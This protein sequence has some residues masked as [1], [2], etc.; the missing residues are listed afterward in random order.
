M[1]LSGGS[2]GGG[3]TSTTLLTSDGADHPFGLL[4]VGRTVAPSSS[5]APAAKAA[6]DWTDLPDSN[7]K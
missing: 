4:A 1:Y 7:S 3:L 5:L 6:P 2:C